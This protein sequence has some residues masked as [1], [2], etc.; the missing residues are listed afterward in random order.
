MKSASAS[1]YA[2]G[3]KEGMCTFKVDAGELEKIEKHL[4]LADVKPIASL[5]EYNPNYCKLGDS[6]KGYSKKQL[7]LF[8]K[9]ILNIPY[10]LMLNKNNTI[11]N[12]PELCDMFN[13]K[14]R[15]IKKAQLQIN[16]ADLDYSQ[17]YTKDP[18]Q[19]KDGETKGGYKFTELRD[20]AITFFGLD[21][22]KAKGMLKDD[23]CDYI[24]PIISGKAPPGVI[25]EDKSG[26]NSEINNQPKRKYIDPDDIYPASKNINLCN[27]PIKRGGL[28]R[29][30]ATTIAMR[31]FGIED[32]SSRPKEELCSIIKEGIENI[33]AENELLAK[34]EKQLVTRKDA[35]KESVIEK[36]VDLLKDM[37]VNA[38]DAIKL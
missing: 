15:D 4:D 16:Q 34:E 9:N 22:E 10:R 2:L 1:R 5:D 3:Y 25:D 31:Y 7:Y 29:K 23:L 37:K 30:D 33:K 17:I 18:M 28:P 26:I 36:K 20:M 21:E 13:N 19:C 6:K 12:K 11:L 38:L 8:G 14:I 27:K 24:I 35:P 32:A